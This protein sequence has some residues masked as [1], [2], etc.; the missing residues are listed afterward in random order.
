MIEELL[1][2][3]YILNGISEESKNKLRKLSYREV[4]YSSKEL[5]VKSGQEINEICFILKGGLKCTEYTPS[6]KELNSSY[7]NTGIS[8]PFYL[9][10]GGETHYFFNIYA[11]KKTKLVWFKWEDIKPIIESDVV[12]TANILKEVA[13]YT[14]YNKM[15]LRGVQYRRVLDRLAYWLIK[16]NNPKNWI[17]LPISQDILSDILHVNRS[18][19]NQEITKLQKLGVI[20]TERKRIRVLDIEY[21][22]SIL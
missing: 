20:E 5:I 17:E 2:T 12:F 21:L 15:I 7:F 18:T 11:V 16:I 3:I 22:E 13:N 9:L 8:Y 19:L 1:K 10:Y 6:G 14:C 4:D